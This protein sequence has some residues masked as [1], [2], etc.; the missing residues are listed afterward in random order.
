MPEERNGP[1]RGRGESSRGDV[2]AYD[3][4]VLGA[5]SAAEWISGWATDAVAADEIAEDGRLA[6]GWIR[7]VSPSDRLL[8]SL[9][10][11]ERI[12]GSGG[13]LNLALKSPVLGPPEILQRWSTSAVSAL[14]RVLGDEAVFIAVLIISAPY[15]SR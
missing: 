10:R 13:R 15:K 9:R 4:K 2:V 7:V 12:G 1:R 6:S 8:S 3:M 5:L 14:S 11:L